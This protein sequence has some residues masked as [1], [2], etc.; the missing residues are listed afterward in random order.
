[1]I[2]PFRSPKEHKTDLR[3]A[4]VIIPSYNAAGTIVHC[5]RAILPQA[6]ECGAEVLLVDSS[7]DGTKQ[8][9]QELFPEVRLVSL[10]QK[11]AS[12]VSRNL[13]SDFAKTDILVFLDA[14]CIPRDGWLREILQ[15]DLDNST[16]V[17]GSIGVYDRRN[18]LGLQLHFLE[19]SECLPH[20]P[21]RYVTRLPSCNLACQRNAFMEAGR[22]PEE[23]EISHDM[24]LTWRL[25]RLGKMLFQ[26]SACVDHVNKRGLRR[27]Y[28]YARRLGYWSGLHWTKNSL[29]RAHLARRRVFLPLLPF[30]RAILLHLRL[31]QCDRALWLL[32]LMTLPL[33]L[34]VTTAWT[35]G[36]GVGINKK[37]RV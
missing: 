6:R 21:R 22:F 5:L 18:L 34:S 15:S 35:L 28:S 32:W 2:S 1:M 36:F 3:K 14:D 37:D 8:I 29:P 11:T 31:W 4:S 10:S 26:P 27:V 33:Y 19:F 23:Y 30:V 7:D 20:S 13:G 16:A 25:S 12:A 17:G 9:V 24:V